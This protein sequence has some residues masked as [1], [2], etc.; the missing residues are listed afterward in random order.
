MKHKVLFFSFLVFL[1]AGCATEQQDFD[2]AMTRKNDAEEADRA[3][4]LVE[5]VTGE[6]SRV[7]V[8]YEPAETMTEAIVSGNERIDH[9]ATPAP[10]LEEFRRE[11]AMKQVTGKVMAGDAAIIEYN[12]PQ[13]S[14]SVAAQVQR[15]I[16]H[17][18][19][20]LY[21]EQYQRPQDHRVIRVAENPVS[22]FSID[23]DTGAYSN[24]RRWLNQG[25]LPP[26]DAVRV[27]EFVNYFDYEYPL[28]GDSGT[29]FLVNTEIAPSP[30]NPNTHLLRIGIQ[31][32]K[33]PKQQL[34]ASNLV[35]LVDVSG[36]MQSPDKLP[37]LRQSLSMLTHELDG[38]DCISLV[39]YA[40]ASGVVLNPTSGSNKATILAALQ[41]LEA[42]GRTNGAAG[43][44]LA[45]QLAQQNFRPD[46]VNRVILATDGDFNVGLASTNELID[47]IQRKREAGIALTTL[48]FG[49]GNYND[50]LLEQLA[51]E[52][53]GNYAYI[54]RLSEARKVLAEE[55]TATLMTI[56]KD[57][58]IQVEFNPATVTEYRLIGYENRILNEEDFNND[59]VDAGEIGAGHRVTA[60][61][62][63][64]L[65]DSGYR[66]LPDRRYDTTTDESA[67]RE[68]SLG[69]EIAHLRIRYKLPD[70]S[71]SKLIESPIMRSS[72]LPGIGQAS[73]SFRFAA[74]V[75]AF[76]QI[77][78]GGQYLESWDYGD[79]ADLARHSR[80]NDPFG[81]RSEFL[82]LISLADSLDAT[83]RLAQD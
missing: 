53:N 61:Y 56:A 64:S 39:V 6:D 82:Q 73:D 22:T 10:V 69:G 78:R 35:F 59:R 55:L 58:K 16:R 72:V 20:R 37:L 23:V 38:N 75:A 3:R 36:S 19:E 30:W 49:T 77:L 62:E 2:E 76:G 52:G 15:Q 33:V 31:G 47:L 14:A 1:A 13:S 7:I 54:D 46:G 81:Y 51:D 17:P 34:P 32:Y 44:R 8:E 57:V 29:P 11:Q 12:L 9:A 43:I 71:V 80:G 60:L 63:I 18:S 41:Q 79:I 42:G 24:M 21:R 50:H 4:E 48:G 66:R 27:E 70:Q 68:T 26:E 5:Q 65:S 67:R 25:Q 74:A 83:D 45:Y 28:P 40:G